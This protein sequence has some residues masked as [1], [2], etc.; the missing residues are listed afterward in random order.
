MGSGTILLVEDN[1]DDVFFMKRALKNAEIS[2][3][4]QVVADGQEAIDYLNGTG[5]FSNRSE[6]PFPCLVL[7]DLKLPIKNGHEVLQWIRGQPSCKNLVVI[8]LTT[9]REANDVQRAYG[10]GANAFLVKPSGAPE[11][12][13]IVKSIKQF[14]LEHNEFPTQPSQT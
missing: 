9:S 14:W 10:F 11:L 7:L 3:P 13:E 4:L 12:V 6:Y 5:N 8:V 1:E 2:N